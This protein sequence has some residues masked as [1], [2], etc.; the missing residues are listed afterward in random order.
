MHPTLASIHIK[1]KTHHVPSGIPLRKALRLLNLNPQSYLAVRDGTLI[2]D[3]EVIR[4]SDQIELIAV[5]SGG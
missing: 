5:I 2:T 3:D 1:H 4:P